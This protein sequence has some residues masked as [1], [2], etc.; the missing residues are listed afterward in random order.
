MA[1]FKLA[2]IHHGNKTMGTN[3]GNTITFGKEVSSSHTPNLPDLAESWNGPRM[4]VPCKTISYW[5]YH[6]VDFAHTPKWISLLSVI[7]PELELI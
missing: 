2:Q 5:F 7:T 1:Q 6:L 3:H 4:L